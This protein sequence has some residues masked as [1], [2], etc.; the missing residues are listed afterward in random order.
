MVQV[1]GHPDV[2][3][4]GDID[5]PRSA[6]EAEVDR[7]DKIAFRV[8]LIDPL[9]FVICNPEVFFGVEGEVEREVDLAFARAEAGQLFDEFAFVVELLD[10]L[11]GPAGNINVACGVDRHRTWVMELPVAPAVFAELSHVFAGGA[12]VLNAII[13]HVY[14]PEA[15]VGRV[16]R[17]VGG[18]FE[19]AVAGAF[20]AEGG[21][22]RGVS[23]P[24]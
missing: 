13:A 8:E 5:A 18:V 22:E 11:A 23:A 17:Y 9:V 1:F 21:D 2:A 20:G 4:G 19:F 3:V 15:A 16:Y 24:A 12:E 7:L 10:A 6:E 14:D